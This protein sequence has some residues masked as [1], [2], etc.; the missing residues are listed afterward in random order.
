MALVIM[1]GSMLS[2]CG[3][4]D[5]VQ[6]EVTQETQQ[7]AEQK[8]N[9]EI[10]PLQIEP[11]GSPVESLKSVMGL[12][13]KMKCSY[14]IKSDASGPDSMVYIE[15]A[16]FRTK[17]NTNGMIVNNVFDGNAVYFWEEGKAEGA[18]FGLDCITQLKSMNSAI[19]MPE[20]RFADVG[21]MS[22]GETNENIDFSVPQ[23]IQFN[24]GCENAK[25]SMQSAPENPAPAV[26]Q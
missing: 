26:G 1:A 13:K 14:S 15:G 25:K 21:N 12:N 7:N 16:K 9:N 20:D 24:D 11:V 23:S 19:K 10:A 5:N 3:K 18:K 6:Q 17:E 4:K 2:G 22:C 8:S